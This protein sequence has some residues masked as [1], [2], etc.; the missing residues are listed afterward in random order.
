MKKFKIF[1]VG[2]LLFSFASPIVSFA[3][4]KQEK[5]KQETKVKSTLKVKNSKI[6]L[7]SKWAPEN[8]FETATD[9]N[10][11]KLDWKDISKTISVKGKVDT[12][13]KGSYKITYKLNQISESIRVD[14]VEE[15]KTATTKEQNKKAKAQKPVS[16]VSAVALNVKETTFKVGDNWSPEA[17]FESVIMSD[18]SKLTWMDISKEIVVTGEVDTKKAGTYKVTYSYKGLNKVA[19]IT[20]KEIEEVKAKDMVLRDTTLK[21]DSKWE[22]KDNFD[23]VLMT[24]GSKLAWSDV[25]KEI[26]VTG[27]VDTKKAGIYK[28]TYNYKGL[29]KVA[30][31]TVKEIEEVKVKDMVLRDT[32]LKVDSKWEAKDNFDYVLMTDGSKL[33][34]SDVSKEIVV[35]GEVDT[36]KAGIYKVT[37]NYKGL[38]KVANITVKETEEVKVKDMELK[39]T[40]LKVGSK[41]E[42]KDNFSYVLMSDGSKL[43]WEDVEKEIVVTG[44]VDTKKAGTYKITYNFKDLSRVAVVTVS[45]KDIVTPK[46]LVLKDSK[47]AIASKWEAKDNFSYALMSDGSKLN[48][49]DVEKEIVVTGKV[50]TN[51]SGINKITYEFRGVTNVAKVTVEEVKAKSM[52]VKDT[53]IN[54]GSKWHAKDNFNYVLMENDK[55]LMWEDVEKEILI[56]GEV[57]TQKVGSYKVSYKY[58]GLNK[59]A[60]IRVKKTGKSTLGTTKPSVKKPT[61]TKLVKRLPQTGDTSS[62]YL[63]IIGM[64][65]L[66]SILTVIS[67]KKKKI[68][69]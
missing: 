69:E 41:W 34:W 50:D 25:S 59:V 57:N 16:E 39:D 9:E 38:S 27:E 52:F 21:V 48:W 22:A 56:S 14:V 32:T 6:T 11:K 47:I 24:D 67:F 18:D 33:A 5:S 36:K 19:N 29:N 60:T 7:N 37:Y 45:G 49:K 12:T 58:K 1:I 10:G 44:E 63:S 51:K 31:I 66:G 20:V 3:E 2:T 13:K 55:K 46:K 68:S 65:I 64:L 54:L 53:T 42:A 43:N 40:T 61:G 35:T 15:S 23:Y 8:N 26:V 62:S 4:T 28:V 30:D 17:T